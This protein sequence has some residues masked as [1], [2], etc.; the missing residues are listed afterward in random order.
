MKPRNPD[1]LRSARSKDCVRAQ[2]KRAL[3]DLDEWEADTKMRMVYT[4]IWTHARNDDAP[5]T[6]YP[7]V[8][9]IQTMTGLSERAVRNALTALVERQLVWVARPEKRGALLARL[10]IDGKRLDRG[11]RVFA[12]PGISTLPSLSLWVSAMEAQGA[13]VDGVSSTFPRVNVGAVQGVVDAQQQRVL[14]E[15]V[16]QARVSPEPA[17]VEKRARDT[18]KFLLANIEASAAA[19][20]VLAA[21]AVLVARLEP[22]SIAKQA[23]E[24]VTAHRP[25]P[26]P[27]V[28]R[29]PSR[30]L[31][32]APRVAGAGA[33]RPSR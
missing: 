4:V 24:N 10:N 23:I 17:L 32:G 1:A 16:S 8:S 26:D 22:A 25:R 20:P 15:A 9:L 18:L 28:Q 19:D 2:L 5:A 6:A 21:A 14:T 13:K 30:P 33:R 11:V 12:L 3:E 7:K 27:R 29:A 31:V